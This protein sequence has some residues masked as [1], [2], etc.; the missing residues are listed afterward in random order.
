[1]ENWKNLTSNILM[2]LSLIAVGL[3][4]AI[5]NQ[6]VFAKSTQPQKCNIY[7][8]VNTANTQ[9]LNIRNF[10]SSNSKI[11]AQIPANE[12]VQI[13]AALNE[14]AKITNSSSG[15][16]GSGW[17]SLSK[18]GISTTGYGT[19]GVNIYANTNLKSRKLGLIP[20]NTNLKLIDCQGEWA[21]VQY[22]NLKGWLAKPDQCGA[23]L[24]SCS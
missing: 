7:G 16:K 12:T 8:Y 13:I 1:M 24:T 21:K 17:V 4:T 6:I 2:G 3:N 19:K 22:Q 14:W 23:A 11:I 10:A 15:F 5:D 18:L 9:N 20:P